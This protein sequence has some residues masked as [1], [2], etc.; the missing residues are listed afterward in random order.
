MWS[1]PNTSS[2]PDPDDLPDIR[3]NAATNVEPDEVYFSEFIPKYREIDSP[4]DPDLIKTSIPNK[5]TYL[6]APNVLL[7]YRG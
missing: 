2:L 7:S 1:R 5:P 4:D 3:N 6:K